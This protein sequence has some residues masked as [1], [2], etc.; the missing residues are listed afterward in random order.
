MLGLLLLGGLILPS[1]RFEICCL[2][3]VVDPV[4]CPIGSVLEFLQEKFKTGVAAT[5]LRVY[6]PAF[7][8]CRYCMQMKSP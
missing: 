1:R 7:P 2:A 8:A 6:V 5:T 3:H 4:C